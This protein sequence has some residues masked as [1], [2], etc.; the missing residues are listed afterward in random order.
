MDWPRVQVPEF[1]LI[2]VTRPTPYGV[3]I[4]LDGI[5]EANHNIAEWPCGQPS[6][7]SPIFG[8]TKTA[9]TMPR[10]KHVRGT[11]VYGL[12]ELELVE[13]VLERGTGVRSTP[14]SRVIGRMKYRLALVLCGLVQFRNQ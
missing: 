6:Q 9:L 12:L 10:K 2:Y 4:L 13:K 3:F 5:M 7:L 8:E 14:S 1:M 11:M